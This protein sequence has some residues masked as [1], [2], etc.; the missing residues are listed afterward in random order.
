MLITTS[1]KTAENKEIVKNNVKKLKN[2]M[3]FFSQLKDQKYE[4]FFFII[5]QVIF[6]RTAGTS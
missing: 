4:M 5:Q 6:D 1:L 3:A 2:T